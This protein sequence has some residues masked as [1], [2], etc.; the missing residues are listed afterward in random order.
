[1]KC[2]ITFAVTLGLAISTM[3]VQAE[4]VKLVPFYGVQMQ[5]ATWKPR[6][7]Q[8]VKN[9][10]PHAFKNTEVAR[11]RLRLCAEW[12]ESGGTTPK[13]EPHRFNT[14]DLYKVLEGGALMLKA[15]PHP[16][17]ERLMDESIEVIARA[18]KPDG[19]LYVSHITGS[20]FENEMGP[21]PYSYLLHSHELYNVGHLY[22]AAVA[23]AQATGKTKLLEVA[24]KNAAHVNKVIFEG[25]DPNYNDG[26]PVLQAPGHQE[27]EIGL[28]KLYS[29][30]GKRLYLEMAKKFLD[31]R[32][33]TFKPNLDNVSSPTY[34]QQHLPVA[35]QRKAVGHAVRATYQYAAMAEVDSLLGTAEYSDALDSIWHDIVDT[36]M[37]ITGGLGAV[38]G[39]EGFGP[40][41][42][43]PNEHTYLETCAAV[44]NVFFNMR[45]FLKFKDARYVDVAEIALLNNCLSGVGLDGTSFFYPNPL[46]A[47]S[48]HRPRSG[49]FG[50]ACCPSNIARLI[51]QVP[52]YL[53]ATTGDQIYALLYAAN[54][55]RLDIGNTAVDL[56]QETKYPYD[57]E[58]TFHVD[59]E[60]ACEFV[61]NLRVPTWAGQQLVPGDLYHFQ[62][63]APKWSILVNGTPIEASIDKGFAKIDRTWNP[64]DKVVLQLP[65]PVRTNVCTEKVVA[66][67]SRVAFSRGP[68]VFCAEGIDNEGSVQRFFVD[69]KN[70][71]AN[72]RVETFTDT[73]LSGLPK[74]V[75]PAHELTG[76]KVAQADD[77][78]LVPY[79]AWSNRDRS[80]MITWMPTQSDL[81]IPGNGGLGELK[82]AGA[83]ASHTYELD[84][85]DAVRAQHTPKSSSDTNIPRWT[86]WPQVGQPQWVEIDL[87]KAQPVASVGVY[88]YDDHGGVQVPAEWHIEALDGDQWNKVEIYNTDSYSALPDTYNTVQPANP[89]TT[90]K[91]RIHM[92]PQHDKTS[93]GILSVDVTMAEVAASQ[94]DA[95]AEK[96]QHGSLE[97]T[98]F[99][100]PIGEGADPWVTRDP[101]SGR[102][103]W[104][105]S[106][107]NRALAIHTSDSLTSLG[108]KH[109]V[110]K[111][112]R[113][114]PYSR[115]IWAPELHFLDGKWLIYFAG[116]DGDNKNHLAYA[117][118]SKTADPLG[119]Y[120][121]HGAFIT[122]D[123]KDENRWAI[124]MTALEHQ[125]KRYAIWSGWDTATS[126]RQYLYIAEMES[127]TKLAGLRVRICSNDDF[128]W[129]LTDGDGQGRGLH[130]GPQV[131]QSGDRTFVTYSCAA[132][133]LPT[134][135]LGMLELVGNNPLDPAAWKKYDKPVFQ[136][137]DETYGVGHSCFVRSPDEKEYWHIFHAKRDRDPGWRRAIFAQP[138]HFDESGLPQFGKPVPAGRPMPIPSGD[139]VP[140]GDKAT[141][142]NLPYR[143]DLKSDHSYYGHHQFYQFTANGLRLGEPPSDPINDYRS[144]EKIV[145]GAKVPNDFSATISVDFGDDPNATDAGILFRVTAPSVGYDAQRG[146]FV[147]IKPCDNVVLLGK[148]DGRQWEELKRV[149]LAMDT[150]KKKLSIT[151]VDDLFEIAVDGKTLFTHHDAT[152]TAGTLGL[153]VVDS[154]VTFSEFKVSAP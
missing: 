4:T 123:T 59:P 145:L 133:W 91:L 107:G 13:P 127:P 37:H 28:V 5:D 136:S 88:W 33:V 9:T 85:V 40:A 74:I 35:R 43:L 23:Y 57:G 66:N 130:E 94:D 131:L 61:L 83:A 1:M 20:I 62:A 126:D 73:P 14:S 34:A 12:L 46:E 15:A 109:I 25:G 21:R 90:G 51:P 36:K 18:Q 95:V 151:V 30:T 98:H 106:D 17:I 22:E 92:R 68:I 97:A 124:D 52:G 143:S 32:G 80:S 84:T 104:C 116:S 56:R 3:V 101:N 67:R 149:P 81:A 112:P 132:S 86:G 48:G 125:G 89:L 72:A 26:K 115:E 6:I 69:P 102:Y 50:T 141:E 152:Y 76:D 78:K 139:P 31:I 79:F 65:M 96:L 60:A 128:P 118:Q 19:Y 8:L 39:I 146:Y 135:K 122:G 63:D 70:A 55:T 45:M 82:F 129:E 64:G 29:H 144:G 147:G 137:T 27:I 114:G 150:S 110:W 58:V 134:Y 7:E 120:E 99:V 47:R 119:E 153:R 148:T 108:Q 41:Y 142:L 138:F 71:A 11:E 38:H 42:E 2:L 103:L 10:L 44:G 54:N 49:W 121:L 24:E 53:Y 93:V 140:S 77:V 111:A 113:R 75:L 154:S 117:L 105:M 16:E 100:N 87:G